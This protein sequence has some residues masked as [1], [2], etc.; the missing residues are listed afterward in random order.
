MSKSSQ[1]FQE[2]REIERYQD[3]RHLDDRYYFDLMKLQQ[4]EQSNPNN[5]T[6]H[7]KQEE[8]HDKN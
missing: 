3:D 4:A 6:Q 8:H 1:K 7:G 2:L 5:N